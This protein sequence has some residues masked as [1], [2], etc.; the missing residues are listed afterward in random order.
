M[1]FFWDDDEAL[2][3]Q[4]HLKPNQQLKYLNKGSCHP[5]SCLRAI[6]HG[7]LHRL[8][9]L[10]T[11]TD[12][13]RNTSMADLYPH[14]YEAMRQ[15]KLPLDEPP[16]LE[17]MKEKSTSTNALGEHNESAAA[18][19]RKQQERNRKRCVPFVVSFCHYWKVPIHK[20]LQR[21]KKN[22]PGLSWLR[23]TMAYKR[24]QNVTELFQADL[25]TKLNRQ[26][27]SL[28]FATLPC[29]CRLAQGGRCPYLGK[30]REP[31]VVY[32]AVCLQTDKYYLG[33]TQQLKK[34]RL[35]QHIAETKDK[36]Y[37][38]RNTDSFAAHFCQF[39]PPEAP[40]K[41]S[42][43]YIKMRV[44]T[45]WKGDPMST[46]KTFGS[47]RCKL[48][49]RERLAIVHALR[50]EP[51]KCIN[52]CS[53]LYG[54]CRHKP[55]FHRFRKDDDPANTDEPEKGERVSDTQNIRPA[56]NSTTSNA[57]SSF[58]FMPEGENESPKDSETT[59]PVDRSMINPSVNQ[60]NGYRARHMAGLVEDV[61]TI[62][63]DQPTDTEPPSPLGE[64][65]PFDKLEPI[66]ETD[67]SQDG[68]NNLE[69]L[70]WLVRRAA[71]ASAS[72]RSD[73]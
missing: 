63:D 69:K 13:N 64:D 29:N 52:S 53:E 65:H 9:K 41:G 45:V 34:L 8:A 21:I 54:A 31:I 58:S 49:A 56:P 1:E 73:N 37:K 42:T 47:N 33:C 48:C 43:K 11:M 30:C 23:I 27:E 2:A 46:V 22:F 60:K 6:P 67:I 17:E 19:K 18:K 61:D 36:V 14:H 26:V 25:N 7:V 20:T 12:D 71:E 66:R 62:Y 3:F 72:G 38:N 39:I 51:E 59:P 68:S 70:A 40:R 57:S 4:V 50:K 24:F 44:E 15:A 28:D 5:S 55:R 16:T 35:Q 10:T 32:K